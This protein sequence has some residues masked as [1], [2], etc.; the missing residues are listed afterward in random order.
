MNYSK[1][2]PRFVSRLIFP[3]L[4][5]STF[6]LLALNADMLYLSRWQKHAS[7][8]IVDGIHFSEGVQVKYTK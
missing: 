3:T 7:H 8:D 5:A 1:V 2:F 6:L 4:L